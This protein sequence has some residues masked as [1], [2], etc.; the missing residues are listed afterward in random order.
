MKSNRTPA[1]I[2][3]L[4]ATWL[5]LAGAVAF[6]AEPQEKQPFEPS[7]GQA[8]KDVIWVPTAD[9][10]VAKMLDFAKVTDKDYVMDLGSGDGRIVIA[11]AKRGATAQGIEY[12]PDMV[13]LSKKNAEKAGVSAKATF[14]KADI[15]ATDFSKATVVTMYLLPSLNMK[16]RPTILK[17][18]PGTRVASHDFDMEDWKADETATLDEGTVYFWIVPA[19]VQ[20]AWTF[21]SPGGAAELTLKQTFQKIEPALKTGGKDLQVKDAKLVGNKIS[22]AVAEAGGTERKYSGTVDGNTITGVSKAGD[23]PEAKWTAQRKAA[24]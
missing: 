21:Q 1:V 15:F 9:P 23:G 14:T 6:S 12:N 18:K 4:A 7:V 13:E 11:A 20:G 10:V 5:A 19:D 24:P 16:L 22:F 8:G 3:S 17:M 2:F